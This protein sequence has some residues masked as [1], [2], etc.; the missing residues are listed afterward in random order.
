[1]KYLKA[2]HWS[3]EARDVLAPVVIERLTA[4]AKTVELCSKP[5]PPDRVG[6]KISLME[7][8]TKLIKETAILAE[9]RGLTVEEQITFAGVLQAH[10]LVHQ[11]RCS[12][13]SRCTHYDAQLR[14]TKAE[15]G[16]STHAEDPTRVLIQCR[17]GPG[18]MALWYTNRTGLRPTL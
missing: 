13:L 15:A 14:K 3:V 9:S 16:S 4:G 2:Q 18:T 11:T 17:S 7:T 1:M 10:R 5:C 6:C 12:I 8:G